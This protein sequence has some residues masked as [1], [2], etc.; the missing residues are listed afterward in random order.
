MAQVLGDT[1]VLAGNNSVL[2][3]TSGE[4]CHAECPSLKAFDDRMREVLKDKSATSAATCLSVQVD[5][6][7]VNCVLNWPSTCLPYYTNFKQTQS[8]CKDIGIDVAT[9][10]VTSNYTASTCKMCLES[11]G[12]SG[13]R[14]H[15]DKPTLSQC[16]ANCNQ[17]DTCSAFDY[18]ATRSHCRTWSACGPSVRTTKFGCQWTVYTRPGFVAPTQA[19]SNPNTAITPE[20]YWKTTE[21]PTRLPGGGGTK[22]LAVVSA[23]PR[24]MGPASS[25]LGVLAS[26]FLAVTS[27]P[28]SG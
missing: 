23:A 8:T 5:Y 9:K 18:D 27:L 26:A 28:A 15:W 11:S 19:P 13:Q 25:W 17:R 10:P 4:A 16:E 1:R 12:A 3:I 21:A 2:N 20:D 24:I 6:N 7:V 22:M 14:P